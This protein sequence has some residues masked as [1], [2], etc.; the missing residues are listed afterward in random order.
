MSEFRVIVLS[1]KSWMSEGEMRKTKG[2]CEVGSKNGSQDTTELVQM[3]SL[4]SLAQELGGRDIGIAN[5]AS[6]SL[7]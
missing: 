2:W 1:R 6:R 7:T 3:D 4:L 5:Q